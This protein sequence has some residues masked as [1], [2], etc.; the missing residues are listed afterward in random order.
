MSQQLCAFVAQL[1]L[2]SG[3]WAP[4]LRLLSHSWK[5][6]QDLKLNRIALK[7]EI[8]DTTTPIDDHINVE[9]CSQPLA[10]D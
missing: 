10:G 2:V 3:S 1:V 5:C 9:I 8:N 6:V 7:Q 4:S